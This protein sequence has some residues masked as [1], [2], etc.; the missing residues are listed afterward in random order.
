L[1]AGITTDV[2]ASFNAL[3]MRHSQSSISLRREP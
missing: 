1:N 3:A 2:C